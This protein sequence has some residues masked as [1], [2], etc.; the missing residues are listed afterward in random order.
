[1]ITEQELS[2][3]Q[4]DIINL[5]NKNG[6]MRRKQI[7]ETLGH[8][9]TTIYDNL[10]KLA[11]KNIIKSEVVLLEGRRGRPHTYWIL[12]QKSKN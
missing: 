9:R 7:C 11:D 3:I 2:P 5:L 6:G 4:R 1:M 8:A 12:N 10:S